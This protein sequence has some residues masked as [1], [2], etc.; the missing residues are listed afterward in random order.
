MWLYFSYFS[1]VFLAISEINT[2]FE[3]SLFIILLIT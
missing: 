3:N 1:G 2:M